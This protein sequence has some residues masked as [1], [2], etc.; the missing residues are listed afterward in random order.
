MKKRFR[1]SDSQFALLLNLPALCVLL[2]MMAY[3]VI[4]GI[5]IS[6]CECGLTNINAPTWNNFRNYIK[7]FESGTVVKYL[8]TTIKF[9]FFTV[10]AQLL[11]ALPLALL[12]N[13]KLIKGRTIFRGI[14]FLAWTIP[15]IVVAVVF[16]WLFN[17][18]YGVLN[19]VFMKLG[20]VET[21][22]VPW[23]MNA[24]LALALIV[25]ACLWKQ[26]PYMTVMILAG[27][28]SVDNS[29]VEAAI[30]DGASS[31][32]RLRHVILPA[33]RPV[34]ITTTWLAVVQDFQQYTLIKNITGGGPVDATTTLSVG[35]FQEAFLK[36]NFGT[37]TAIGV[38]WMVLLIVITLFT[39]KWADSASRDLM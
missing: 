35:V 2:V 17:P 33:L 27:L 22:G 25:I 9:V 8:V 10:G 32:Q 30:V 34:L 23:T 11:L 14:I 16:R 39:N 12:L 26:L 18:N 36:Y 29:Q 7:I 31:F 4:R 24:K 5:W 28:Q 20:I 37:A 6:F 15:T 21:M 3:P 38:I 1:V 13:S 19:W